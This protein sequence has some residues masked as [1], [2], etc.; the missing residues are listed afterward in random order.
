MMKVEAKPI[1]E[2]LAITRKMQTNEENGEPATSCN[3]T[4]FR[5]DIDLDTHPEE[6]SFILMSMDTGEMAANHTFTSADAF[7]SVTFEQCIE[8]GHYLFS[9]RDSWGD[10]ISCFDSF[11]DLPCYNIFID[12]ELAIQGRPFK[13]SGSDHEFD[14]NFLCLTENVVI[15]EL[16]FPIRPGGIHKVSISGSEEALEFQLAPDQ[17]ES[18]NSVRYFRCLPP[19]LYDV[20]FATDRPD[21][22]EPCGGPCYTVSVNDEIVIDGS[23]NIIGFKQH[24][25]FITLDSIAREQRCRFNPLVS[26]INELTNF[27]F[28]DRISRVLN[29]I[30]ALSNVQDIN[31]RGSP[32][33]KATCYILFDDLLQIEAEDRLLAQRYALAVF[34]F[35]TFQHT[36]VLLPLDMCLDHNFECSL[37]GDIS[38]VNMGKL[39]VELLRQFCVRFA[40]LTILNSTFQQINS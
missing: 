14:S 5:V 31:T 18:E 29:V 1:S 35:S 27:S 9:I 6:T 10:G 22:S 34:L 39:F 2:D 19:G 15:Y 37:E 8:K 30:Q 24:S 13:S 28:D 26:P 33:Y 7:K 40:T 4:L 16:N 36:E 17:P 3:G 21:L 32:Q 25:F 38:H 20:E 12:N 11:D 23:T